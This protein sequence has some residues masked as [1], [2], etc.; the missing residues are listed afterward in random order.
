MIELTLAILGGAFLLGLGW[1]GMRA[2][3]FERRADS[4]RRG[5][6]RERHWMDGGGKPGPNYIGGGGNAPGDYV[7]GGSVTF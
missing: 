1:Y 4:V 3:R 6:K 2:I 5:G 7:S